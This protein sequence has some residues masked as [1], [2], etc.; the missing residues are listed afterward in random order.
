MTIRRSLRTHL[1]LLYVLL[2]LLS[3]IIVPM[4]SMHITLAEFRSYLRERKKYDIDELADSLVSLYQEDGRWNQERVRD[5]LR[6]T[7]RM[8]MMALALY[9]AERQRV[10]PMRTVQGGPPP[11]MPRDEDAP[12]GNDIRAG[13]P[14][15]SGFNRIFLESNGKGIGTLVVAVPRLPGKVELMFVK[16]LGLYAVVGAIFMVAL[17]CALGFIVAGGLS[18]P[19]LRAAERAR[20][21][22]RGEYDTT[23]E[24]LSGIREMDAL[25]ESVDE[26]GHALDGQEKLRKRLMVD[27]AHELRTP[28]TVVKSQLEALADGVWAASPERLELCVMEVDRLSEL[29][30]EVER[31]SNLEGEILNLHSETR[32]LGSFLAGMLDSFGQLFTRAGITLTRKLPEGESIVADIDVGR[33]R[34][35]IENL[36]SNA[37]R[38]TEPGKNVEVRL[39]SSDGNARIEIEDS[40]MGIEPSDL[41]HVFDR[42]YR[43]DASRTRG[44][45]GRGVGL[46]IA[47]AAV[48]AHGG[49][50]SVRS[51]PG[52]GSVFTVTLPH[53]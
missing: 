24:K 4:V 51:T 37:L 8:P 46:A 9:D 1:L 42:F 18:R 26:L 31:L 13:E 14:L 36:L 38:Y 33:F 16:R 11:V 2:A 52:R 6:Q 49:T 32:D 27:I 34:H 30:A 19:V 10:F 22:S 7:S 41:P 17:A 28:L 53:V 3:G 12:Q 29:I 45:G 5:V 35:V 23:P 40:G 50:I 20:R 48:E 25:S 47:R 21:I 43:A 15:K 39:D 44:T